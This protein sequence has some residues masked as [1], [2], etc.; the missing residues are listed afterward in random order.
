[1][2]EG[3]GCRATN[4]GEPEDPPTYYATQGDEI[5]AP[6]RRAKLGLFDSAA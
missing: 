1:M 5:N 4:H 2:T 6:L 3:A